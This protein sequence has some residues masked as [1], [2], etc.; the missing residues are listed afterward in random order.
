MR[1]AYVC[2]DPGI[3]IFGT[4]GASIHVQEM[5]R[6][7]LALGADVTLISPRIEGEP[8]KDLAGI[9]QC[10]LTPV[11]KGD[12]ETRARASLALNAEVE[13]LL[14]K[15][16]ADLVYERHALYAHAGMEAARALGVPGILEVNAPLIEEQARHRTLVL[17]DAAER[18]ARRSMAAARTICAVSPAVAEHCRTLGAQSVEVVPN[19]ISPARFPLRPSADGPFTLGFVG[20]LKPWHDVGTAIEA[21]AILRKGPVPDARML[22][23]GDGP[24]RA[25]LAN[26]AQRLGVDRAVEFV[27]AVPHAAIPAFLERMHVGVAPYAASANFY[28]SPLKLYEYM[29]AGIAVV[30]SRVGHLPDVVSDGVTGVLVPPGD[31]PALAAALA[32]LAAS[33][34]DRI[35]LGAAARADVMAHRTWDGVAAH[36]LRLAGLSDR[37]AA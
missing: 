22:I 15:S 33:P 9:A 23:V 6:A 14:G 20:S 35:A 30:A 8:P 18:S 1:I 2:T 4:K 13:A 12:P 37:V 25:C 17:P 24:E 29:A 5:L 7:F 11:A 27:G 10:H 31:A 26:Q 36:V 32:D 16:A 19:A 21:L 28:F 34:E 3:P